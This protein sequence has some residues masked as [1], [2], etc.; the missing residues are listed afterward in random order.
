MTSKSIYMD[1]HTPYFYI[2]KHI[3]SGKKY[4]GCR[5]GKGCH[6]SELLQP[7]GYH[8]SSKSVKQLIE[9][10]G[11]DSF[12]IIEVIDQESIMIPFGWCSIQDYETFFLSSNDCARNDNWINLHNN[13]TRPICGTPL[14]KEL[15]LRKY[16][17]DN[18]YKIKQIKDKIIK[19]N[20]LTY[21]VD[22]PSQSETVKNK[23]KE[24]NLLKYGTDNVFKSDIIKDKIKETILLKYGVTHHMKLQSIKDKSVNTKISRYG[25]DYAK[26][27]NRKATESYTNKTGYTHNMH[28]PECIEK[29]K[30]TMNELYGVDNY[31]KTDIMKEMSSKH[32]IEL[33]KNLIECQFCK[34]LN[35]VGTHNQ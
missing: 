31:F 35:G 30:Q 29:H 6:P 17:H 11:L 19:N 34:K 25:E 23:I 12:E 5:Y 33:N 27:Q 18:V 26:I 2:I 7:N 4:A 1:N 14:Y 21:G 8:T 22:Y 10:D 13:W 32:M 28:N 9:S 15:M 20:Q 24:T 3:P 16:G